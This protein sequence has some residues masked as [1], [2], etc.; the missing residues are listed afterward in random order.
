MQ[1]ILAM[2]LIKKLVTIT[3]IMACSLCITCHEQVN[4]GLLLSLNQALSGRAPVADAGADQRINILRGSVDLDGSG[5]HD[6]EGKALAYSWSVTFQPAGSSVSFADSTAAAT[7]FTFDIEGTYEIMLTVDDGYNSSSD[8]V[9]VDVAGNNGPTADAGTDLEVTAGD[10]VTLDGSGSLDQD[11][12]S[13]IYTWTQILGPAIG[14]GTLT[15]VHPAFTAPS[16]VC[17]LAYDLRVD[18]GAGYSFS[19]RVFI[20]IMRKGGAAIY[21]ATTGDDAF[22]GTRARPLKT[23]Q[24]GINAALAAGSDVYMGAGLYNE[25]IT[26]ASGVSLF[27][28]FDPS[29]WVRDSFDPSYTPLFTSTIQGGTLAVDGNGISGAII[30]GL[31]I[32]SADATIA[33]SGSC[34]IRLIY[35]TVTLRHCSISAGNGTP[36]ANGANRANGLPGENGVAGQAGAKDNPR[37]GNGGRGG[38]GYDGGNGG[39][40]GDGGFYDVLDVDPNGD[41][42]PGEDGYVGLYGGTAGTGGSGGDCGTEGENGSGGS[43]GSPGTNGVHGPG[44]S[45]GFLNN[46]LWVSA[47]GIAGTDGNPGNGGGGGGGG[48]G[49][50]GMSTPG[51]GNGGGGGGGGGEGGHGG[52]C[53]QGGGGSFGLFVIES[54][55]TIENCTI[56][57]GNG[58]NGGSG[59]SG[60]AGGPGGA[61]GAGA[62]YGNDEIG[63]GGDGGAGG[64]GG[65]GGHGGGGAGGPSFS[66]FKYGWFSIIISSDCIYI[67]GSGGTGGASSGNAGYAGESGQLGGASI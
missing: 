41:G 16:E 51:T 20:F 42:E 3:A 63:E 13:L 56:R 66:T 29:T 27:G 1:R 60:G 53:G 25:S 31:T 10:V 33:G 34:G 35:S 49:Q 39:R 2:M 52:R 9:T 22:E 57:S 45:S 19:D 43:G 11:G 38:N 67:Y 6:P 54:T 24:A 8:L 26:L 15:G 64:Q 23:I 61:G 62:T 5:S 4:Q 37:N 40:G 59:G 36:G 44:G 55:I 12:D 14:T 32:S 48:G 21:V 18:D 28:G 46:N 58:G 30:E 65:S 50:Y 17:T 7:S 47:T